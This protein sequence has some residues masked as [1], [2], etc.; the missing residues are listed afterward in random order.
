MRSLIPE[1][2]RTAWSIVT[3]SFSLAMAR[4]PNGPRRFGVPSLNAG[5]TSTGHAGQLASSGLQHADDLMADAV[6]RHRATHSGGGGGCGTAERALGEGGRD[7]DRGRGARQVV[8][9]CEKASMRGPHSERAKEAGRHP[10]DGEALRGARGVGRGAFPPQAAESIEAPL[11]RRD[12]LKIHDRERPE[13]RG[14]APLVD[15]HETF[16]VG[17]GKPGEQDAVHDREHR[18]GRPDADAPHGQHGEREAR[19]AAQ[20]TQRIPGVGEPF[21]EEEHAP[22]LPDLVLHLFD[23]AESHQRVPAGIGTAGPGPSLCLAVDVVLELFIELALDAV[24][25][26][27]GLETLDD[28]G[29]RVHASLPTRLA[30]RIPSTASEARFQR[31]ARFASSA[32]PPRVRM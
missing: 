14:R 6:D 27:Q 25:E 31:A 3:S 4:Y 15:A 23:A 29:Q 1:R 22:R 20:R 30:R 32:F 17:I 5:Q 19:A 9:G 7:H 21:L 18:R 13:A 28:P 16:R 11:L 8:A 12:R 10:A 24:P 26:E 2:S